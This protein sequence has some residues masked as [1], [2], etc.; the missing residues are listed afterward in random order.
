MSKKFL[1][2]LLGAVLITAGLRLP[3]HADAPP[4]ETNVLKLQFP[5]IS[6]VHIENQRHKNNLKRALE[7]YKKIAPAY[8][9]IA[10]V[11]DITQRGTASQYDDFMSIM[12]T[13]TNPGAEKVIAIGNHEFFERSNTSQGIIT[14]NMILDRFKQKTGMPGVYYDKWVNGY[15]FIT[16]G[17]EGPGKDVEANMDFAILSDTQYKWLE[18][19]LPVNSNEKKPIF[20]FLHQPIDNTTYGSEYWGANLKDGRLLNLLKKYPQVILFSG[21]T[22]CLLNHP[23]TVYQDGFTMVNTS[24]VDYT[25]YA[26]GAAPEAYSQGLLVDVYGDKVE[27]KAREFS[28]GTWIKTYTVKLPF[29]NSINDKIKPA[30]KLDSK[31]TVESVGSNS[32]IITWDGAVDNTLVDRYLVKHNGK[33]IH[34]E[35]IKFW[36]EN[37][38]NKVRTVIEN[39][40]PLT[41]YKFEIYAVDAWNNESVVPLQVSLITDKPRG[42]FTVGDYKFYFDPKTGLMKKGWMLEEYKWYF[43]GESG[44]METGW[45][46]DNGSKY[47]L[48]KTGVMK[49]GWLFLGDDRYYLDDYGA[50]KTGWLFEG[51]RWYYFDKN[52]I[53]KTGWLTENEKT[54]YLGANGAMKTGEVIIEG[55]LYNFG[56]TGTL[57]AK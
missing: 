34:T 19:T 11:G 36:E 24:A 29:D 30:F 42:W 12:N 57:K 47:Y 33:L 26:N 49:T 6:D 18:R 9:A 40:S 32:A 53:M 10:V 1:S 41:A 31:A 44:I 39:L 14:D 4:A 48:S 5:V 21:H 51:D 23:R 13:N 7:D 35:Y 22:H 8:K 50:M 15:H 43:F 27:I 20:V 25:W 28:T 45:I 2:L 37:K 3:V 55:K 17:S 54:Y 16:L 46:T 52:G 38:L 56:T